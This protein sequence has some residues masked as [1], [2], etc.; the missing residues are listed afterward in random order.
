MRRALP[1]LALTA[2]LLP[3]ALGLP[4]HAQTPAAPEA[5]LTLELNALQAA[6]SGC[7]LSFLITNQ[8]GTAIDSAIYETVVFDAAG[9]VALLT[10]LDF[11]PLPEGKPRVRQFQLEGQACGAIGR[12]LINGAT[13]CTAGGLEQESCTKALQVQ[14]RTDVELLG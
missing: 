7:S 13:T 2:S 11:G 1:S 10:L 4:L 3:P 6:A 12:L 8:T 5:A 14:S 9:Q